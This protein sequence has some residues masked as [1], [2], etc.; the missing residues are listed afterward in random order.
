M[1]RPA[2]MT[3]EPTGTRV[4]RTLP[5]RIFGWA[6]VVTTVVLAVVL[7][8][9][10]QERQLDILTPLA[11]TGFVVAVVWVG[12]LRP[13]VVL[14]ADGV[15]LR[16]MLTDTTVPF[17]RLQDVGREWALELVDGTGRKYSSWAVPVRRDF[18]ARGNLD[19]YAE[20]TSRGKAREAVHADVVAGHVEHRWQ[21]WKLEGGV[22]EPDRPA[23]RAWAW[24]ALGPLLGAALLVVLAFVL[25]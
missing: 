18:R 8:R 21:R 19:R 22:A 16:N 17:S 2:A 11:V 25:A 12:L 15:V 14:R 4:F 10:E 9:A 7:V 13:C 20:A 23:T 24:G 6:L 3:Q 1:S 5:A